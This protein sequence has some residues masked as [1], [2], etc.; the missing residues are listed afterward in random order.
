MARARNNDRRRLSQN[1]LTDPATARWVVRIAR[2]EPEDLVVE[3]GPGDGALTRHLTRDARRVIAHELDPRL[4]DR[5]AER[6]RER[7]PG[8]RVVRGDFTLSRPPGSPFVVVGNIPYSRTSDIVRWCLQARHLTSA[9]LVTQ[10]EYARKRTGAYGRWSKV[11]VRS[12]P[13]WSW[14]LAGRIDRRRFRPVPRVDSG[15]LILRAR[16][17]PL[18]PREFLGEYRSLVELGFGGVGGSLSASLRRAYPARKVARAL[19]AARVAAGAPVGLVTP[20]QWM[21]LTRVLTD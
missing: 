10:L 19:D 9:T 6:Y 12:W 1:F 7:A 14:N 17:E 20:G 16:E 4:A 13:E 8:L 2:V 15:V 5:L 21:T 3:V 18:L 11:T